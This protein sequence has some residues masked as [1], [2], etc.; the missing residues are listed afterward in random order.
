MAIA[1]A[2]GFVTWGQGGTLTPALRYHA[3]TALTPHSAVYRSSTLARWP[4]ARRGLLI[5]AA[6]LPAY[7]AVALLLGSGA[8][9][10]AMLSLGMLTTATLAL[11]R[12]QASCAVL[13][14]AGGFGGGGT[15]WR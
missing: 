13:A 14:H 4:L 15:A 5:G 6:L 9:L 7:A 11:W 2:I 1:G 8:G 12:P 10:A 3:A